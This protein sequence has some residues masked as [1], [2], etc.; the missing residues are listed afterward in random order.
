MNGA[1]AVEP[2][3]AGCFVRA[4]PR[5]GVDGLWIVPPERQEPFPGAVLIVLWQIGRK[6]ARQ[7]HLMCQRA[8]QFAAPAAPDLGGA[9]RT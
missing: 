8:H 5:G 4:D 7:P 6:L 1:A 3:D 9:L 2:G